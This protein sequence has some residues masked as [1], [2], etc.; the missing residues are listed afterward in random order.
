MTTVC[1]CVCVC[2]CQV[3]GLGEDL[4]DGQL[5]IELLNRLA[6]PKSI[7][8]WDKNPRG[9]LQ[10]IQNLGL[11]LSFCTQQNIKLVNI[12]ECVCAQ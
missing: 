3:K 6:A 9:K 5:L 10:S 2:V 12:G 4:Q 11:A 7:E 8:K 1:V